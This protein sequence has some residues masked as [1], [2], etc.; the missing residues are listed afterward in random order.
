MPNE[1]SV[2]ELK[3]QLDKYYSAVDSGDF[4]EL[5]SLFADEIV[6]IRG[7]IEIRGMHDFRSFYLGQRIIESGRHSINQMIADPPYASVLGMFEGNL[8]TGEEVRIDFADFF[9]FSGQKIAWRKTYF[10]DREV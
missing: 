3:Q 8:K 2:E 1:L 10:R 5:F 4:E 6:Y 7:S 9:E